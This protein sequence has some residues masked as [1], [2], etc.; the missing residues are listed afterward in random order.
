PLCEGYPY[1]NW[2]LD[3]PVVYTPY[4][5]TYTLDLVNVSGS[6][7]SL[8][9][10]PNV[11]VTD[12]G[13]GQI[14]IKPPTALISGTMDQKIGHCV[15][16]DAT[17]YQ[18]PDPDTARYYWDTLIALDINRL[19]SKIQPGASLQFMLRDPN[20]NRDMRPYIPKPSLIPGRDVWFGTTIYA[21]ASNQLG[22]YIYDRPLVTPKPVVLYVKLLITI[23][24]SQTP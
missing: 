18:N 5:Y 13:I 14:E 3:P 8:E 2:Y 22:D 21:T 1:V 6:I 4:P 16:W 12:T 23:D 10:F 11:Q 9:E 15:G 20:D 19:A 7:T 17:N 24:T